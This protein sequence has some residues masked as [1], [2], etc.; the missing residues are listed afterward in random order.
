M[1]L[2]DTA[3]KALKSK[4]SRYDVTDR[5]GL[6]LEVHPSGKKVWRYRYRLNGT[7]EKL[8]IG[9]YPAIGL[10]EARKRRLQ[11]EEL[12]HKNVS[13]SLVKKRE[14]KRC[15]ARA[16]RFVP[17]LISPSRGSRRSFDPRTSTLSRMRHTFD[18]TSFPVWAPLRSTML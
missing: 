8:T 13:P 5:D 7:R 10:Q 4:A 2:N 6:L 12:V 17:S 9:P 14:R 16:A 11:A 18:T 1:S 3:I 15:E